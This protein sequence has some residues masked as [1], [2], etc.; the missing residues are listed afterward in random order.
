VVLDEEGAGLM[1]DG[2]PRSLVGTQLDVQAEVLGAFG[3]EVLVREAH[4]L[5]GKLVACDGEAELRADAGRLA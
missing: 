4:E 1:A 5:T 2:C 3:K